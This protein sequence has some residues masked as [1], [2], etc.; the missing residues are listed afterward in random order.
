MLLLGITGKASPGVGF[1]LILTSSRGTGDT[2]PFSC[3][4]TEAERAAYYSS[5]YGMTTNASDTSIGLA[6]ATAQW[7]TVLCKNSTDAQEAGEV[8]GTAY[9]A[10]DMMQIVDALGEDG[11]L[12]YW[13]MQDPKP[14]IEEL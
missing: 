4:P 12:R 10:R 9:T 13:G 3:F 7:M 8:I 6:W 11:M 5:L 2:L 14:I 1:Y